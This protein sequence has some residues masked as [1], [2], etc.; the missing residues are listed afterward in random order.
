MLKKT[1]TYT[2]YNGLERTEDFYFNLSRAELVMMETS[3][4]GG[5]MQRLEKI[6]KTQDAVAV[7]EVFRDII[8]RAY[9]EKS[10]DGKRFVKSDELATAFEQTEAYSELIMEMI[11]DPLNVAAKFIRDIMPGDLAAELQKS[12]DEG[13][14]PQIG[15]P[16][17]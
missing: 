15:S 14:I 1:I 5:M 11:N 16:A 2:D 9:G 17:T 7:M 12:M 6:A 4:A 10:D 8:H 13:K 3:V